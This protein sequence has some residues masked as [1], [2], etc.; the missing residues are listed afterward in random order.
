[1][2]RATVISP[3]GLG[4]KVGLLAKSLLCQ[5]LLSLHRFLWGHSVFQEI[6]LLSSVS[7]STPMQVA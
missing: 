5:S 6:P 7:S 4:W 3:S 2:G 1:M